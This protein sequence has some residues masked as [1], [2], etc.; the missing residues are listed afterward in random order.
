MGYKTKD[1]T[2]FAKRIG[3]EVQTKADYGLL[4]CEYIAALNIGHANAHLDVYWSMY[5][6]TI[7]E[8]RLFIDTPNE[9]MT[10]YGFLDKDEVSQTHIKESCFC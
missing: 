6:P 2:T 10:N 1:D 8:R 5:S 7:V 9:Y 3:N 4:V